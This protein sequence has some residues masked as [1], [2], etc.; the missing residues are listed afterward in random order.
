MNEFRFGE[1]HIRIVA[2]AARDGV[3]ALTP[4]ER[5]LYDELAA[6]AQQMVAN[7]TPE[8]REAMKNGFEAY[9]AMSWADRLRYENWKPAELWA[10]LPLVEEQEGPE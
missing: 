1:R 8:K 6:A 7:V 10:F 2:K 3:E 9:Q 4:E 5:E